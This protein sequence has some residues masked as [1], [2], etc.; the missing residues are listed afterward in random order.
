MFLRLTKINKLFDIENKELTF[1]NKI[2]NNRGLA[3]SSFFFFIVYGL[4]SFV[5]HYNFRTNWFD[6]GFYTNHLY[7]YSQFNF[8]HL[9]TALGDHF[10][11]LLIVFSPLR[12]LFGS[13]T[14]LLIQIVF[15]LIGG[16]GIYLNCFYFLKNK[17]IALLSQIV[18]CFSFAVLGAIAFDYHSNV[19][20]A[21]LIPHLFYYFRTENKKRFL[22]VFFLIF[23]SKENMVLWL[24]FILSALPF[25][26][27]QSGV[28]KKLSLALSFFSLCSFFIISSV[29]MPYLAG[30]DLY[31]NFKYTTVGNSTSFSDVF[32]YLLFH[33][34][35][36]LKLLFINT[37]ENNLFDYYKAEAHVF[38]LLSGGILFLFRPMYLWAVLPVYLQKFLHDSENTWGLAYQYNIEFI[39]VILIMLIDVSCHIK[40]T[41]LRNG[42][43]FVFLFLNIALSIRFMD[44]TICFVRHSG[45]RLYQESHYRADYDIN[46]V[47]AF[48][49]LIPA[50]LSVSAQSMFTPHISMRKKIRMYDGNEKNADYILITSGKEETYPL[51]K[52]EFEESLYNLLNNKSYKLK[53]CLNEIYLFE[54]N[55]GFGL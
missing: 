26:F 40:K 53:L 5:N 48:M 6:L 31:P 52:K 23:I 7:Q 17:T 32:V 55:A 30:A 43:L 51:N 18:F 34:L 4:I 3:Y 41:N 20:A 1:F 47:Y 25:I 13:Y 9:K 8:S 49:S 38:I 39:P 27:K 12:F 45:I 24:V 10:D 2:Q 33:P 14:L 11:L 22:F 44:R 42:F 16:Y 54:K 19:I 50:E 29:I 36:G 21:C 46:T 35:N 15:I 28:L 37:S